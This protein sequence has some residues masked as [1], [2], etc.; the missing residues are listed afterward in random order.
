MSRIQGDGSCLSD[1][2]ISNRSSR[3][4]EEIARERGFKLASE[5]QK[6]KMLQRQL[7]NKTEIEKIKLLHKSILKTAPKSIDEY[8]S[9]MHSYGVKMEFKHDYKDN[10]VGAKFILNNKSI[11]ASDIHRSL[12]GNRILETIAKN[13]LKLSPEPLSKAIKVAKFIGKNIIKGTNL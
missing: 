6:E 4:A 12:S 8:V 2:F 10:I 3:V 7:E 9:K 1:S 13:A 5:V 11:K